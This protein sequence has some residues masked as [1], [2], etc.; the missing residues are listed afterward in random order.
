MSVRSVKSTRKESHISEIELSELSIDKLRQLSKEV[1]K[2]LRRKQ[3]EERKK[4]YAQ[5][6]DLAASVG[7]TVNEVLENESRKRAQS[8]A[9]YQNPENPEQTW[10]GRGKRPKWLQEA[11]RQGKRLEDLK[12]Q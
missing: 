6:K 11:L 4:I 10:S 9:K 7:M 8:Q 2:E 5:M 1:E 3:A 12:V